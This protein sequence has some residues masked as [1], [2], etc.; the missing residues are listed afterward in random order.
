MYYDINVG[1]SNRFLKSVFLNMILGILISAAISIGI[2]QYASISVINQL[3]R[4]FTIFAIAEVVMVLS[5]SVGINKI[6]PLTARL[7]FFVYSALNGVTLTFIG[8]MYDY[9]AILY[10]FTITFVIFIVTAIYGVKTSEDLSSYRRFFIIGLIS[11]IIM[12]FVN[13]FFK[14]QAIYWI[15]TLLGVVL[16]TGLIAFD[17]N[18]IKKMSYNIDEYDYQLVSK[19]GIIGALQLYL[20]FINLFLYILRFFGRKK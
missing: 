6:N 14:V 9:F 5:L 8:F 7:L 16:V 18:R 13:I 15:E 1:A 17:V 19:M 2:Y 3:E 4:Y 11:L 10:A 20:D 12:S